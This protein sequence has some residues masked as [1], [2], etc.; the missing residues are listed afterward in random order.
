MVEAQL[1]QLLDDLRSPDNEVRKAA[2]AQYDTA[3]QSTPEWL[4]HALSEICAVTEDSAT[5]SIGLILLRKLFNLR[6]SPF[7]TADAAAKET[8]KGRMLQ[9]LG[10]AAFGK[11]RGSAAACVSALAVRVFELHQDWDELWK[12]IFD[13]IGAPESQAD[14]KAVCCEIIST[15]AST[16]TEFFKAHIDLLIVGLRNCLQTQGAAFDAKSAAFE[17]AISLAT[18]GFSAKVSTL[19]PVM[20]EVVQ[21]R[22]NA[23]DWDSAEA[24][25]SSIVEGISNSPQLFEGHAVELLTGMMQ[26]AATPSVSAN[27]RYMAVESLLSFCE[28]QP[29]IARKVPQFPTTFFNLLFQYLLN[30]EYGDNWDNTLDEEGED[31]EEQND[32]AIGANGLDRITTAIGGRKLQGTAQKLF[33]D[34]IFSTEWRNKCAALV[35]ICYTSEGFV[36]VFQQQLKKLVPIILSCVTNEV[37]YVRYSS[38]EC[39]GQMCQDFG[40]NLQLEMHSQMLLPIIEALR[41]PVPRVAASAALCLNSFFHEL[42]EPEDEDDEN[43][44]KYAAEFEPYVKPCCIEGVNLIHSTQYMFVREAA[45]GMLS[46]LTAAVK[47]KLT[48]YVHDLVPV[49]QE[50]LRLP[51]TPDVLKCKCKAIECVTLLASSAGKEVFKPYAHEVCTYLSSLTMSGIS[52]DDLRFRFVLRAWTCMVECLKDEVLPY[53]QSVIPLLISVM[54]TKCDLQMEDVE[55]GGGDDANTSTKDDEKKGVEL[56][57]V[58]VPGAGEKVVKVHTSLIEDKDLAMIIINAIVTELGEALSPHFYEIANIA[59]EQLSFQA[60][61]SIRENG[62]LI[63]DGIL[64]VYKKNQSQEGLQL[65]QFALNP[66][67]D[68]LAEEE[69]KDVME[70][71]MSILGTI[72]DSYPEIVTEESVRVIS[73]KLLATLNE[74]IKQRAEIVTKMSQEQDEDEIDNLEE[75]DD[76]LKSSISSATDLIG[77]LLEKSSTIFGPYFAQSFLPLIAGWLQPSEDDF[78]V[79][80]GQVVLC[81]F[82]EHAPG[83]V[84]S[85]LPTILSTTLAFTGSRKDEDLLQSNFYLINQLVQYLGSQMNLAEPNVN[86]ADFALHAQQALVPYFSSNESQTLLYEH[87][88]CN[89]VSAYVSMLHYFYQPLMSNV[90]SMLETI[91]ANLPCKGDTIEAK[92]VHDRLLLWITQ[93]H[94]VLQGVPENVRQVIMRKLVE[95]DASCLSDAARAQLMQM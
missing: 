7:D 44:D 10:T 78:N 30:A 28:E 58:I 56:I 76:E 38:L 36:N 25:T 42:Y 54:N 77:T 71:F 31:L 75:T 90:T 86:G 27:A 84:A 92:R 40:P 69:E 5:C 68:A 79:Q 43:D 1:K 47:D 83:F 87:C 52:N 59:V 22:L 65:A 18:L 50:V 15:T 55:V 13:V 53:M 33:T 3:V 12:S 11:Q 8:I 72:V 17:A 23:Q 82:V 35:L 91:V 93:N 32:F 63:V 48:P 64:K 41:D 19:V 26:V 45:L 46:S 57:R 4:M 70:T 60:N 21:E 62:A 34:N 14:L 73:E 51:D 95:A 49:Y 2:E 81:D 29:K 39:L 94:P 9:V 80:R 66:L 20:L 16:M 67:L 37:K 74:L 88:T 89:A 61:S 6:P 85:S 24:F